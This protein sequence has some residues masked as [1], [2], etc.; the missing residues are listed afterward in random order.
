MSTTPGTNGVSTQQVGG[1]D[2]E[3]DLLSTI[4]TKAMTTSAPNKTGDANDILGKGKLAPST[5]CLF[6]IVFNKRAV[7]KFGWVMIFQMSLV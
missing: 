5:Q 7:H 2:D 3:F 6:Y 4:R 1:I